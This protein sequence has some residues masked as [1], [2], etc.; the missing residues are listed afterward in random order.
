MNASRHLIHRE[1]GGRWDLVVTNDQWA[2][3][4]RGSTVRQS[5]GFLEFEESRAG[6]RVAKELWAAVAREMKS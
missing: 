1:D 2:V 5:F 3:E 6:T 4:Y